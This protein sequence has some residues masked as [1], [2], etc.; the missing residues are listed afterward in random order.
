MRSSLLSP[1]FRKQQH[2]QA[3]KLRNPCPAYCLGPQGIESN[4]LILGNRQIQLVLARR[5]L[6][7]DWNIR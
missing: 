7:E 6:K 3:V 2:Y 1:S 5:D 4:Y